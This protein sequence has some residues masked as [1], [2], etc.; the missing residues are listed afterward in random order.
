M[1]TTNIQAQETPAQEPA[2]E[3]TNQIPDL[4]AKLA[5][6]EKRWKSEIS[7]LNRRNSELEKALQEK[8][9]AALSD[10]ERAA[11]EIE[12][13]KAE[14]EKILAETEAIKTDRLKEK[15]IMDKGLPLDFAQYISAKDEST[16][17]EQADKLA[18]YITDE[19]QRLYKAEANKNFGGKAPSGGATPNAKTITRAQF[20]A[21]ADVKEKARIAKEYTII[22]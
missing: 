19:A 7:G 11:K 12:L 13:A 6:I 8:E 2:V 21:I 22:N 20:E 18:K 14:K 15:A 1:D 5:E 10:K 9:L 3:T 4:D 17:A 16:I